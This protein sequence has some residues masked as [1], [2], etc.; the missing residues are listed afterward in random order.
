M[1]K[2]RYMPEEI[3]QHLRMVELETG[4]GPAVFGTYQ[5]DTCWRARSCSPQR[6]SDGRYT[7]WLCRKPTDMIIDTRLTSERACSENDE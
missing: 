6:S 5:S 1:P 3:I 2:K 4:K 7:I